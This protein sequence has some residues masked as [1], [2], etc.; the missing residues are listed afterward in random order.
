MADARVLHRLLF[1][2]ILSGLAFSLYATFEVL[3]PP[4]E[5]SCFIN[6]YLSCG[7]VDR[8][9]FTTIGPVP[10]WA[11]GVGGFLALLALDAPL[12]GSY[13]ARWLKALLVVGA[14]GIL[15]AIGL[16]AVEILWIHALCPVC[17][18]AYLSDVGVVVFAV[19]LY[20]MRG[21]GE[22]RVRDR[23]PET[24]PVG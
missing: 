7:A 24:T 5:S 13:D 3:Y 8:S 14:V 23:M 21:P 20:R 6:S 1:L 22:R 9:A 2:C 17:L 15:V 18:G 11:V 16:G 12:L 19:W 4:A 10:D